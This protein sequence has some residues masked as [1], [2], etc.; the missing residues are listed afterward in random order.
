MTIIMVDRLKQ[1]HLDVD[2]PVQVALPPTQGRP[3]FTNSD[4]PSS[5][6]SNAPPSDAPPSNTKPPQH[7]R[8]RSPNQEAQPLHLGSGGGYVAN[9]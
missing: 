7:S 5:Q 3:P 1:A 8:S 2:S 4:F 6:P 9:N